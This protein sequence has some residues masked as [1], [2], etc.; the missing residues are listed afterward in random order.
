MNSEQGHTGHV[1]EELLT[2]AA[3]GRPLSGPAQVHLAT[4]RSCQEEQ[5]ML[6]GLQGVLLEEAGSPP[7]APP[8]GVRVS[9]LDR[10][11]ASGRSGPPASGVRSGW[12]SRLALGTAAVLAALTVGALW[13]SPPGLAVPL[14]DPAVVVNAGGPLLVASNGRRP[15]QAGRPTHEARLTLINGDRVGATLDVSAPRPAWF[16]EGVRL[17]GHVFLADAGNDRVLEVQASPLRLLASFP[18]AGGVAGLSAGGGRVYFKSVRGE[19][20]LLPTGGQAGRSVSLA[21]EGEP[22]MADVMDAV[23]LQSGTLYVTH[24]L[25]GELC[26]LDPVTLE[27]RRRVRLGGAPVALAG[28]NGGLLVLDVQGRGD[29]Q[30]AVG[31]GQ[32]GSGGGLKVQGRLLRLDEAGQAQ[33]VW[34]LPG[35]PDK[36]V[37]NGDRALVTDRSGMVTQLDLKTG[38]QNRLALKHPMDLALTDDGGIAVAQGQTGVA[39]LGRDLKPMPGG[40]IR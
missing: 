26:L 16:T 4:C 5:R 30:Q 27:V 9:L 28:L 37:L 17:G 38:A 40:E 14:P 18:V 1:T 7:V 19:V 39:L 11:R 6:S 8:A 36:L 20:G 35:H 12:M 13:F 34:R 23:L 33:Q 3:T 24:H 31:K 32:I 25:R 22:P 21:R 2:A 15:D 29:V 10:A